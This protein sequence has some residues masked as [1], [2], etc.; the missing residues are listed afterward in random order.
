MVGTRRRADIVFPRQRIAIYVDGCFWH[1]CPEHGTIPKANREW[2]LEK[3]EQN[4]RRDTDTDRRLRESGWVV[5]R[6]WAHDNPR[7]AAQEV[8]K[9]VRT[10]GAVSVAQNRAS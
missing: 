10:S 4:R 6:F 7:E 3:F 8:L 2:W 5:L 1:C 9:T